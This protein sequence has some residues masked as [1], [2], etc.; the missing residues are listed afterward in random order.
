MIGCHVHN[1]SVGLALHERAH[2]THC[3]PPFYKCGDGAKYTIGLIAG[4]VGAQCNSQGE[5]KVNHYR[6]SCSKSDLNAT[7]GVVHRFDCSLGEQLHLE[8]ALHRKVR[9]ASGCTRLDSQ[10]PAAI[11]P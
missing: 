8:G 10:L 7:A 6:R 4:E 5:F 11:I 9:C 2:H 3:T 1:E